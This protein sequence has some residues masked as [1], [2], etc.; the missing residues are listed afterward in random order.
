MPRGGKAGNHLRQPCP[1]PE[2][3]PGKPGSE[4]G[5]ERLR[6]QDTSCLSKPWSSKPGPRWIG[7][8]RFTPD[9]KL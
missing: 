2:P 1:L 4:G 3:A 6:A 8:D 7:A 9:G 5:G